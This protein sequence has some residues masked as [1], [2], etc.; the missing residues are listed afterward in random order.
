[1][2]IITLKNKGLGEM[3]YEKLT[4]SGELALLIG[5]EEKSGRRTWVVVSDSDSASKAVAETPENY[6]FSCRVAMQLFPISP[7]RGEPPLPRVV[8]FN[9]LTEVAY[10]VKEGVFG[11][12]DITCRLMRDPCMAPYAAFLA[13]AYVIQGTKEPPAT[14]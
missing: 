9:E 8:E 10:T 5:E 3:L 13:Q 6:R 4:P 7:M 12:R 14:G 2:A 11:I 1:M